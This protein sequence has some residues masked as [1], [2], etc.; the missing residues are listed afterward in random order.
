MAGEG[1]EYSWGCQKQ[2]YQSIPL[3]DRK[4]KDK[5]YPKV[6]ESLS[7][8]RLTLTRVFGR[9]AR[10]YIL[11]YHKMNLKAEEQ[12]QLDLGDLTPQII[13]KLAKQFKTHRSALDFDQGFIQ[14]HV[15][16]IIE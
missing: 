6:K 13:E 9:R 4:G 7:L 16:N 11:A 5:F 12:G 10:S 8:D 14:A 15:V 1:I 3:K 2:W